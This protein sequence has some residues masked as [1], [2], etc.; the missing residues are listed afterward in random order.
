M[1]SL[2]EELRKQRELRQISLREIADATKI[3]IR[4]LEA[5]ER[6]DYTHL[7]GGQ[8]N[9][10]FIRSYAGHIGI[11]AEK[12]IEVYLQEVERQEGETDRV[13]RDPGPDRPAGRRSLLVTVALLIALTIVLLSGAVLVWFFSERS[14]TGSGEVLGSQGPAMAWRGQ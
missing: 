2:G 14:A 10:G 8:F 12:M 4:F 9:K 11:D 13:A 7:P 3:N 6:N 1:D 5:L